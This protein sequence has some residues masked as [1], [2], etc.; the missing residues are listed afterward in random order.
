MEEET[1][2][3]EKQIREGEVTE[4]SE[5]EEA[6]DPWEKQIGEAVSKLGA[7]CRR[8]RDLVFHGVPSFLFEPRTIHTSDPE[9]GA[10]QLALAEEQLGNASSRLA[11]AAAWMEAAEM[12]ALRSGGR[13]PASPLSSI[14]ALLL[15]DRDNTPLWRALGNL[16]KARALAED[17]FGAMERSRGHV[18]AAALL[19]D[20][21]AVPGVDD[22][23][24]A[25]R[26]AAETELD[27][28]EELAEEIET[29]VGA[30]CQFLGVSASTQ[31]SL[32]SDSEDL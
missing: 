24:E 19:L 7:C 4:R 27:A 9:F 22:C 12:L 8:V 17:L 15:A 26:E 25:E 16:Q 6:T 1:D 20:H 14:D 28:A 13:S 32:D 30:A 31:A 29:L 10:E 5:M 3:W 23:I 21:P 11:E 18:G 2:P